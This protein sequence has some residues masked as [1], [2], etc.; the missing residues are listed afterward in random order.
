[1]STEVGQVRRRAVVLATLV[2]GSVLL[3]L[4]LR[5]DPGD[6][7][8]L[9]GAAGLALVW[10][11]GALASGPLPRGDNQPMGWAVGVGLG[12]GLVTVAAFLVGGFLV[13]GL[14]ALRDPVEQ[15]LDHAAPDTA[16]VVALTLLNGVAEELFFR[17]ALFD[18]LPGRVAVPVSTGT[19]ALT[20]I[21]SGVLLLV[22]AAAVLGAVAALLR[23]LTGGLLAPV[24]LHLTWSA[25][26][27]VALPSVLA[28]GG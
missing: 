3:G 16:M 23:R 8:F 10:G 21:G 4:T 22:L 9:V 6:D 25:G 2:A 13:A 26:M 17:G 24:V 14:P 5:L 27:L 19:Y 28:S 1:M 11:V 7:G 15:L 18:A 12:A 20:T